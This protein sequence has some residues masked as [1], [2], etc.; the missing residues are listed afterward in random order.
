MVP[1]MPDASADVVDGRTGL[2]LTRELADAVLEHRIRTEVRP[3]PG[4]VSSAD[5]NDGRNPWLDV[6]EL[7]RLLLRDDAAPFRREWLN[8]FVDERREPRRPSC[9]EPG[10]DGRHLVDELAGSCP[11]GRVRNFPP[12]RKARP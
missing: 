2:H 8:S 6:A 10:A 12:S 3:W 1:I 9:D 11:C 4:L 5:V 7:E